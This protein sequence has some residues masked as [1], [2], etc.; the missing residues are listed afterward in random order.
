ME[1]DQQPQ[2]IRTMGLFKYKND[3]KWPK[4]QAQ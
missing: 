2:G 3:W 4:N 1:P